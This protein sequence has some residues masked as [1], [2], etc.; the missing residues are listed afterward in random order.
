MSAINSIFNWIRM[1]ELSVI[2]FEA[3]NLKNNELI[4]KQ[5][6][7]VE[8]RTNLQTMTSRTHL[9]GGKNPS[10]F[11]MVVFYWIAWGQEFTIKAKDLMGAIE[12]RM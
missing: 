5:D 8:I 9:N 3:R 1:A 2:L 7:Y 6:P 4:G 12:F 10:I 11:L